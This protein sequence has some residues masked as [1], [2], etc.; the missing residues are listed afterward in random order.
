VDAS[1]VVLQVI[2]GFT[3]G[4]IIGYILRT[5]GKIALVAIGLSLL[6][7]VI[8]W[9]L[10]VLYVDWN[11]LNRLVGEFAMWISGQVKSIE[12]GLAGMGVFGLSCAAGFIFGLVAGFG[13][14]ITQHS[15]T[16]FIRV[17][18]FVREKQ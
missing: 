3:L 11:A 9:H 15:S 18:R 4:A 13:H 6:P 7:V 17:K 12:E 16:R 5:L 2:G 1:I 10:G 14:I 8:L